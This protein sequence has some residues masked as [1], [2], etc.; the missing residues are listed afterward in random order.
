MASERTS[1][2]PMVQLRAE[3]WAPPPARMAIGLRARWRGA[4]P[5][6]GPLGLILGTRSIHGFGLAHPVAFVALDGDGVVVRAGVLRPRRI[7]LVRRAVW[8]TEYPLG[9]SVPPVGTATTV[10]RLGAWPAG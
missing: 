9:V 3:D 4:L 1:R 6:P 10:D 7:V 2:P 5:T 8:M